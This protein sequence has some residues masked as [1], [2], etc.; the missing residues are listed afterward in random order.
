MSETV[1]CEAVYGEVGDDAEG[2]EGN[3][4]P[5]ERNLVRPTIKLL[6]PTGSW[7]RTA[8]TSCVSFQLSSRR[9]LQ[10]RPL[11]LDRGYC[12]GLSRTI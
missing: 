4:H 7:R 11:L 9:I 1:N 5:A 10:T 2:E 12:N 3:R 6:L 8:L